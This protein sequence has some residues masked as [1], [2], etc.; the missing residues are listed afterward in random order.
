MALTHIV[1][2][3][4][5]RW[6]S[7]PSKDYE[8]KRRQNFL[9][10]KERLMSNFCQIFI[11]GPGQLLKIDSSGIKWNVVDTGI[12]IIQRKGLQMLKRVLKSL[13]LDGGLGIHTIKAT[14]KVH[15]RPCCFVLE[16]NHTLR[17]RDSFVVVLYPSAQ[18]H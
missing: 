16:Q 3:D 10:F 12:S 1:C 11:R 18:F 6:N 5:V 9:N 7:E 17:S 4:Y 15:C 8:D 2:F 13:K 14:L